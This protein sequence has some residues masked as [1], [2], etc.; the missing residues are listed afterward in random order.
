[1]KSRPGWILTREQAPPGNV[2]PETIAVIIPSRRVTN[3]AV[4]DLVREHHMRS[5][6]RLWP[7][8][9]VWVSPEGGGGP[10]MLRTPLATYR[11]TRVDVYG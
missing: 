8:V 11:L 1:M 5:F 10:L 2:R 3:K 9:V 4:D 6:G 7:N